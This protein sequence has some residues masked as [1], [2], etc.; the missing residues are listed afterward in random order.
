[1]PRMGNIVDR[2][3]INCES[4]ERNWSLGGSFSEQQ[5]LESHPCPH[6]GAYTLSYSEPACEPSKAHAMRVLRRGLSF[7]AGRN[8][9]A[10]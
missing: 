3:T 10:G 9:V 6:C 4:C 1:M 8:L 2:W 5:T 7:G